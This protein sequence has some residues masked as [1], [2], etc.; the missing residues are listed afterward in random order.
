[1][2]A[3]ARLFLRLGCVLAVIGPNAAW[4][5]SCAPLERSYYIYCASNICSSG[6]L[7]AETRAYSL[8]GKLRDVSVA[9]AWMLKIAEEETARVQLGTAP[10][11]VKL[12]YYFYLSRQ[13]WPKT[14]EE[15]LR[16]YGGE[17]KFP[18]QKP[19]VSLVDGSASLS[20][21]QKM[22]IREESSARKQRL[23]DLGIMILDWGTLIAVLLLLAWSVRR[24]ARLVLAGE[25]IGR[26]TPFGVQLLVFVAGL[27]F[28]GTWYGPL[29]ILAAI[30]VPFIWL[31]QLGLLAH[32]RGRKLALSR[33]APAPSDN[34]V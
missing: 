18:I 6:F 12:T 29:F 31:F 16:I 14:Q 4:S 27:S 20:E 10:R 17:P 19:R 1:M 34:S 33:A 2:R 3:L 23:Q 21:M 22:R 32:V 11:I 5:L 7:V 30:V 28:L 13:N 15:Y 24:Y 8:C 26:G 25:T 9:E